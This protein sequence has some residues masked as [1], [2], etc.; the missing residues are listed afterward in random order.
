MDEHDLDGDGMM[1]KDEW[2]ASGGDPADFD[3]LDDDGCG[4]VDKH[5]L[6]A[7]N[8]K[9]VEAAKEAAAEAAKDGGKAVVA[10]TVAT[11]KPAQIKH[12]NNVAAARFKR[13]E[14][15]DK[16]AKNLQPI[17]RVQA[18]QW[19]EKVLL[20]GEVELMQLPTIGFF[21]MPGAPSKLTRGYGVLLLTKLDGTHRLHYLSQSEHSKVSSNEK[22][23]YDNETTFTDSGHGDEVTDSEISIMIDT[24][25]TALR[26]NLV[27]TANLNIDGNLFHCHGSLED[28]AQIVEQ[29]KGGYEHSVAA[30][31][32]DCCSGDCCSCCTCCTCCKPCTASCCKCLAFC[33]TCKCFGFC[34]CCKTHTDTANEHGNWSASGDYNVIQETS[35]VKEHTDD[36]YELKLPEWDPVTETPVVRG[37]QLQATKLDLHHMIH[38]TYRESSTD[39][40]ESSSIL[41]AKD[42]DIDSISKFVS[43]LGRLCSAPSSNREFTTVRMPEHNGISPFWPAWP[44]G[45]NNSMSFGGGSEVRENQSY[46]TACLPPYAIHRLGLP[47]CVICLAVFLTFMFFIPGVIFSLCMISKYNKKEDRKGC[48][49]PDDVPDDMHSISEPSL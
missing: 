45:S 16:A 24:E 33:F 13:I 5:E 44:K 40:I 38:L 17:G 47:K 41:L 46:F 20:E 6:A 26:H 30:G 2:I 9:R 43:Q 11:A 36:N 3:D 21:G 18:A 27:M 8:K 4:Q 19:I 35:V 42:A 31:C 34:V 48:C 1:S 10:I 14:S 37:I 25:T 49:Y 32:G 22:W 15:V 7:F 12:R 23:S 29:L 39:T 28:R